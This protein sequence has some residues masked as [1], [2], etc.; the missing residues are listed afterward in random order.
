MADRRKSHH[1]IQGYNLLDQIELDALRSLTPI[2]SSNSLQ[3]KSQ[4]SQRIQEG[5]YDQ[6]EILDHI[7]QQ[8]VSLYCR[9]K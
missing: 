3:L 5:Y 1:N 9:N 2:N 8:I 4:I 6:T 7:A